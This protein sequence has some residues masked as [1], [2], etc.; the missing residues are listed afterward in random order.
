MN[1]FFSFFFS[2]FEGTK[3]TNFLQNSEVSSA[4]YFSS[5]EEKE[6]MAVSERRVVDEKVRKLVEFKRKVLFNSENCKRK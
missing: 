3:Q 1:I 6:K 2:L 4:F 5:A